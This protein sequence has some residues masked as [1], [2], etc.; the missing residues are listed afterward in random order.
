MDANLEARV[1]EE[2]RKR[3]Q[4][5]LGM[6]FDASRQEDALEDPEMA[7]NYEGLYQS[8]EGILFQQQE[9]ILQWVALI[10]TGAERDGFDRGV[11][12]GHRLKEE[13]G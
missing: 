3:E 13:M 12:L 4:S 7:K 10:H 8:M 5:V 1:A 9:R 11:K 6:L 2:R